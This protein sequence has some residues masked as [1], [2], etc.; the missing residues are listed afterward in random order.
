MDRRVYL[1]A[2][3]RPLTPRELSMGSKTCIVVDGNCTTIVNPDTGDAKAFVLDFSYDS[4]DA[5]AARGR[6]GEED[7]DAKAGW[8]ADNYTVFKDIGTAMLLNALEG[9][10]T[11]F[12]A[13]GQL[14]TGKT[15][16]LIGEEADPGLLPRLLE[17]L[18]Q[19]DSVLD[20]QTQVTIKFME[21]R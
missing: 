16:T 19:Q 1:A 7:G 6:G 11:S 13:H 14:G 18:F 15:Y 10:N 5:S 9:L 17:A 21:V 4:S 12:F 20:G 8:H 2:R 3:V